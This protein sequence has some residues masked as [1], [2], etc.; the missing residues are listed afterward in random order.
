MKK[1][2]GCNIEKEFFMF[3]KDS[4]GKNGLKSRC[5]ECQ[6]NAARD[7]YYDNQEKYQLLSKQ[8]TENNKEQHM[9][10]QKEWRQNNPNY[11]NQYQKQKF[12]EDVLYKLSHNLRVRTYDIFKKKGLVK[13]QTSLD[14]VGIKGEELI[15]YIENLWETGMNWNNYG[16]DTSNQWS[17]D[18][19]IPLSSASNIDELKKLCHYTN[20]QPLWHVENIKKSNKL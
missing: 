6:N 8:W 10:L 16:K 12:E 11:Q 17:V 19:I 1:C 14:L 9:S 15:H 13:E 3:N 20:L 5:K 7:H 4:A 2:K 18:H